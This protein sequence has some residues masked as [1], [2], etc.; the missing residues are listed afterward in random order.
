LH[1]QDAVLGSNIIVEDIVDRDLP[2]SIYDLGSGNGLPGL[3][4]AILHPEVKVVGVDTDER[5]VSFLK[6]FAIKEKIL[7][8]SALKQSVETLG[9]GQN[10]YIARGFASIT[11]SLGKMDGISE[12]GSTFYHFKSQNWRSELENCSTWNNSELGN[13]V[14]GEEERRNCYI[15]KSVK[16]K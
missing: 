16:L 13:Y 14:I 6:A 12:P 7:N 10:I 11:E 1:L 8:F 9:K 3:V 5:K 15:I 4:L 2:R